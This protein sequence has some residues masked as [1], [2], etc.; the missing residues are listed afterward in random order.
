MYQKT[1]QDIMQKWPK[2]EKPLVSVCC[3]TYNHQKYIEEA[4]KGFL[5]QETDFPFEI[6]IHDD[7]STDNTTAI[8][9]DY[10]EKYPQIIKTIIQKENQYSKGTRVFSFIF[11]IAQGDY[12]ALCDADD[13]WTDP[14]KLQI[15]ASKMKEH[16]ECHISFHAVKE[17][18][19]EDGSLYPNPR[20]KHHEEEQ[21][22]DPA[23]VVAGGGS[24]MQTPSIMMHRDIIEN[25]PD[26]YHTAPTEDYIFQL[27]GS[28]NGGALYI[29]KVMGVYRVGSD[30]SWR[31]RIEDV[32]NY[33]KFQT[34]WVDSYLTMNKYFDRKY[35]KEI[36]SLVIPKV[37]ELAKINF[38]KGDFKEFKRFIELTHTLDKQLSF[39][40]L[41]LYYLR[42]FPST[43]KLLY[44]FKTILRKS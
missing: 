34:S 30:G 27:L 23:T 26:F 25:L 31:K 18:N 33:I 44:G 6:I 1:E 16:P 3:V 8:V 17:V 9:R 42:S 7:A 24:F 15:Q 43:L 21:I 39:E 38:K 10:A 4:I 12:M 36:M 13:Y 35:E 11:E 28:L 41:A 14:Q 29:N 40:Y 22:F 32:D 37:K 2:N 19:G 5:M 20:C